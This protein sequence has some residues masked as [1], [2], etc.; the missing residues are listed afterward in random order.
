[1]KNTKRILD[2]SANIATLLTTV[3]S[4]IVVFDISNINPIIVLSPITAHGGLHVFLNLLID[5][6]ESK[7][8]YEKCKDFTRIKTFSENIEI[9]KKQEAENK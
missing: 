2:T 3:L 4:L 9:I 7:L 5:Y 1:M 8:K 6:K